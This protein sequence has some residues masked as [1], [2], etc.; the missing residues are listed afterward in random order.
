LR[1]IRAVGYDM[2]YTLVHYRADVWERKAFEHLHHKLLARGWPL[3]DLT[4]DPGAA[5]RGLVYDIELGN[6]VKANRFGFVKQAHHGSRPL[7][8]DEQRSVYARTIVDIAGPRFVF[9]NT[10]FSLCKGATY[11]Q[12]VDRLDAGKLPE[13]LGYRELFHIVRR[14]LDEAHMEG[15]LKAEV[16][17]DPEC[18]VDLDPEA[19]LALL[20]QRQAGKKLLLITNSEWAYTRKLMAHAFDRFLPASIGTWRDLF[21]VIIVGARK[22]D[23]FSGRSPVFEIVDEEQ[24]LLRPAV[25]G[26]GRGAFFAGN[27]TLVEQKLGVTGDEILYI[28]DHIY[29]DVSVSKEVLRWRTG[30]IVRELEDEIRAFAS[31]EAE[32][33]ALAELMAQK[34]LLEQRLCGARLQLLR[35]SGGYREVP[36]KAAAAAERERERLKRELVE[37]DRRIA[38]LARASAA[39]S[40]AH[41]GPLMRAGNDKSQMARL[42][43][44]Y[45]DVYTSRVSNFAFRCPDAYLRGPRGN[46]PHD[47]AV[48]Q[49]ADAGRQDPAAAR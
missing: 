16:L 48:G 18:Y 29:S 30:L 11:A 6:V 8:Y 34:E 49:R 15:Q 31:A 42:I 10:L 7:T 19:P 40:N 12:L 2:D 5:M 26:L 45:A 21:D 1:A 44:Q 38:P 3:D 25:H 13:V 35:R 37:L 20:D 41:W 14:S 47:E 22:P 32:Q 24:G 28:G 9:A 27:A 39:V 4:F 36:G 17:A 43:E 33:R 23:F 46:L